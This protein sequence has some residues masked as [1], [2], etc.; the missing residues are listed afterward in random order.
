M[1]RLY[2]TLGFVCSVRKLHVQVAL[3]LNKLYGSVPLLWIVL[4]C[5]SCQSSNYRELSG[6]TMGTYFR[7]QSNCEKPIEL[8]EINTVFQG[9]TNHFSTWSDDSVLSRFNANESRDWIA[10]PISLVQVAK[11][12]ETVSEHTMGAFDVTVSPVVELW[13]FGPQ[14]VQLPPS[15]SARKAALK[16]V[17]FRHLEIR[18]DPPALRKSNGIQVDFSAIAKGYGVDQVADLLDKHGCSDYLVDVGGEL[19]LKGRNSSGNPWRIGIEAADGSGTVLDV[20]ELANIGVATSGNYRNYQM[21][22][23]VQYSHVINPETG[24]PI[25]DDLVAVTV[26]D[27]RTALA[28]AYATGLLVAGLEKATLIANQRKLAAVF[29]SRND[30]GKSYRLSVSERMAVHIRGD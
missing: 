20:L 15:E 18:E 28:D 11:L 29:I 17:G 10:V 4:V 8:K 13:G 24:C 25:T 14:E 19:R 12:A 9:I 26:L 7:V 2:G 1:L 5:S 23:G 3:N 30:D 16:R 22:D 6:E 27:P 21:L